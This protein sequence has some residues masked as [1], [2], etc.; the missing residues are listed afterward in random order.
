MLQDGF[1]LKK[2]GR[3][4]DFASV[5]DLAPYCSELCEGVASGQTKVLYSLYGIVE[6]SGSLGGGHYTAYVKVRRKREQED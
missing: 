6:H 2:V 4:V 3:K 1:R 5:L